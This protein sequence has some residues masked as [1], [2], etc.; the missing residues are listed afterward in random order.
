[1]VDGSVK[2]R[3][4]T[5]VDEVRAAEAEYDK[6][7]V[8]AAVGLRK[9]CDVKGR[10]I[11]VRGDMGVLESVR[12]AFADKLRRICDAYSET[13]KGH[14]ATMEQQ[15]LSLK[16]CIE[17]IRDLAGTAPPR[18]PPSQLHTSLLNLVDAMEAYTD[19]YTYDFCAK[20]AVLADILDD[21]AN[22][23][24]LT[25]DQMQHRIIVFTA[26]GYIERDAV[27]NLVETIETVVLVT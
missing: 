26:Q 2:D 15:V 5:L 27:K 12:G 18:F 24:Q 7:Q 10:S 6:A 25:P 16:K 22:R 3:L 23:N 1:M 14:L 4:R 9:I 21:A 19:S 13:V 20:E 11:Y 17:D 8:K